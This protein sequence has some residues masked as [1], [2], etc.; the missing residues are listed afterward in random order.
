MD[1]NAL[2]KNIYIQTTVA[3]QYPV[4][5]HI[6]YKYFRYKASFWAI[7]LKNFEKCTQNTTYYLFTSFFPLDKIF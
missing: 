5:M 3:D 6:N 7:F 1:F 2:A 4:N